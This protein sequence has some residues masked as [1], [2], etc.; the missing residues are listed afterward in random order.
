MVERK[1]AV[2]DGLRVGFQRVI[3]RRPPGQRVGDRLFA[4][5][6][7]HVLANRSVRDISECQRM[8]A[9]DLVVEASEAHPAL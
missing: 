7:V 1:R 3:V 6:V 8:F 9:E 2:L 4:A 5:R